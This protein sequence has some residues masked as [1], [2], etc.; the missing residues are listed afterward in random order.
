MPYQPTLPEWL[1]EAFEARNYTDMSVCCSW[2]HAMFE[3]EDGVTIE[4]VMIE[5]RNYLPAYRILA[6]DQ[7]E[8]APLSPG[9]EEAIAQSA[10][11]SHARVM[12]AIEA[13]RNKPFERYL[14]KLVGNS[15]EL[16]AL[17]VALETE[18]DR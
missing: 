9:A 4:V 17:L 15:D 7:R 1:Y 16:I 8:D 18:L 14:T 3:S 2:A 13:E 12:A 5:C 6:I 11:R 10:N